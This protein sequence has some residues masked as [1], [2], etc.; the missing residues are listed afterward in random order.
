MACRGIRPMCA[1]PALALLTAAAL[2]LALVGP[3]PVPIVHGAPPPGAFV[4]SDQARRVLA[5]QYRPSPT[6]LL[7]CMIGEIRGDTVS[8]ERIAP[9]DVDPSHSTAT[10]VVPERTCE[11]A[12][13]AGTVGTIHTHPAAER[14]WYFFPGTQVPSS[15]G[16]SFMRTRYP[17][18]AI[19]CGNQVVWISRRMV[20]KHL[21]LGAGK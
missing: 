3:G 21:R 19:L 10:R 9:A 12:G 15:D 1:W 2:W 18:D 8:V 4:L 13:W 6:E 17:V 7:G 11:Q 5:L 14:C 16:H 20:Q